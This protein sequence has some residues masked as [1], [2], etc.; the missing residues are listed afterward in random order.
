MRGL[1]M[2]T[3]RLRLVN[4]PLA[5]RFAAINKDLEALTTSSSAGIWPNQGHADSDKPMDPFGRLV[6]KQRALVAERDKLISQIQSLPGFET[7][8]TTPSFDTLR[9]AAEHGPVII[10]NHTKWRSDILILLHDAP[11]SLILPLTISMSMQIS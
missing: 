2:S 7:F 3:D 11:P 4:L 8:L 9:S 1:R 6:V 5:E 10:I